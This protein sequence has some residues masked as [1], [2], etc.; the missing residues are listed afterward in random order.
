MNGKQLGDIVESQF[1]Y[2]TLKRNYSISK[3]FG[4]NESYDFIVDNSTSLY[5]V[6]VKRVSNFS[7]KTRSYILHFK[8]GTGR[9]STYSK[10]E[11]DIFA[12]FVA[13]EN[14]WYL[15]KNKGQKIVHV[16][17]HIKDSKS[18]YEVYRDNWNVFNK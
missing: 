16:F 13:P 11:V 7:I 15:I 14:A 9:K 6:Q 10:N 18:K 12:F 17:P 3:P 2:E 5:R 8:R 1:L 4:D